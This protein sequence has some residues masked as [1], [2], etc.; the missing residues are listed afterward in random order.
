MIEIGYSVEFIRLYNK[1]PV[2]LQ[3]EA[4]ETIALFKHRKNHLALRV[5]KLSGK[6][7]GKWAFDINY[8]DRIMF[9]Y[10]DKGKKIVILLRVGDHNIYR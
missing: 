7:A 3:K 2:G 10:I 4:K 5:H 9:K 6:Y 8:G 1:L